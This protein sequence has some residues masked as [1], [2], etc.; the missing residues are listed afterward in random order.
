MTTTSSNRLL[1]ARRALAATLACL[2]AGGVTAQDETAAPD[3]VRDTRS[4]L[5]Q[6]V[7]T[8]RLTSQEKQEWRVGR[9][10]LRDRIDLVQREATTLRARIGE[11]EQS[12]V[13]ADQKRGDLSGQNQTLRANSD[14]LAEQVVVLERKTRQLLPQLPEPLRRNIAPLSQRLPQD[15]EESPLSLS[16]RFQNVI[17]VLNAINKYHRDVHLAREVHN[18]QGGKT[19]EV[20]VLYFGISYGY[21]VTDDGQ[22]AGVGVPSDKGFVWTQ[23]QGFAPAIAR[24]VA[25]K[26]GEQM[27][28]FVNLP[29]R[30]L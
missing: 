8:R 13:E 25:I 22:H 30:I 5:Q 15:K 2:C 26:K 27:A 17:G 3:R 14:V 29:F 19:A 24:A 12:I 18:L 16:V 9:E 28:A 10:L 20:S 21:Y 7:E 11:A 6:W 1:D 23:S 4:T